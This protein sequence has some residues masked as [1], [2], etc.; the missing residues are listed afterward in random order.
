MPPAA[1]DEEVRV[2]RRATIAVV[3]LALVLGGFS[4][5]LTRPTSVGAKASMPDPGLTGAPSQSSCATCHNA[6]LNDGLGAILLFGVPPTYTPGQDYLVVAAISRDAMTRWGFEATALRSGG[7]MAGSFGDSSNAVGEQTQL[8]IEYVSQ[9]TLEGF[10]GTYADSLGAGWVFKWTAPPQGS[11]TVTF[12]AAGVG[13]NHDNA[14]TGDYTY[15]TS[16]SS[17]EGAATAVQSTTWGKIKQI[18]R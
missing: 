5:D 2:K 7:Q 14:A 1:P 4:L 3:V 10:D 9:T 18:Y 8:G 16:A 6:G 13:A 12:Y 11:G 17:I 15:T